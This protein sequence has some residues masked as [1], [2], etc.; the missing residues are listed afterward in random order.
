[1]A[2][3][4]QINQHYLVPQHVKLTDEQKKQLLS[5]FNISVK[6]LPMIKIDDPAIKNLEV[7]SGDVILIKRKSQ[8][9][10]P[11]Q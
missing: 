2:E 7:K 9:L 6:Q 4:L 11:S 1:M 8:K 3:E 10:I 5:N